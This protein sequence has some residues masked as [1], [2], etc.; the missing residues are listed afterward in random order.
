MTN[1]VSR[2]VEYVELGPVPEG[3]F[4]PRPGEYVRLI[5]RTPEALRK[6]PAHYFRVVKDPEL[7]EKAKKAH[8]GCPLAADNDW[9]YDAETNRVICVRMS[10]L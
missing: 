6:T 8:Q 3:C 4:E 7:I 5:F 10:A 9:Q 1:K 2:Q